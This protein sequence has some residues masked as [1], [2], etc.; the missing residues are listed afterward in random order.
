VK[1]IRILEPSF[2]TRGALIN[3]FEPDGVVVKGCSQYADRSHVCVG[4]LGG[5]GGRGLGLRGDFF[6]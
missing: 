1:I 3:Q 4:T 6:R 5:F 2:G